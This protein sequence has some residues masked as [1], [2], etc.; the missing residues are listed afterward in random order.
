MLFN[1]TVFLFAFLPVV[2]VVFWALRSKNARYSWL[3]ITGY[4]FYGYW[5]PKF[6]LLMAFSTLVSYTAGLGFLRWGENKRA[7]RWLL[8][9]PIVAD[10]SLLGYFKYAD[11]GLGTINSLLGSFGGHQFSLLHIVLPIGISFY[12]FHTISYIVDCYR[13][14]IKPT[15]NLLEFTSF[16][17]LFSQLIAGPIVRFRELES[18]LENIDR[19]ERRNFLDVGCSFFAIGMIQKVLIA[20]T[21]ASIID[22]ALKDVSSL[23]TVGAWLCMLGYS[24]QLFF[25]FAGYSNMAVG[26][27]FLFGL[28]IPQNF[29]RPYQALNPADF[30]RRWHMS[31]SRVFRDYVFYPLC[32]RGT[33]R[34]RL[35]T[36]TFVTMALVGLWHGANWTFVLWGTYHGLLLVL[37]LSVTKFWDARPARL[38]RVT[39]FFLVLV[40]WTIF[41]APNLETGVALLGRLVIP[42]TGVEIVGSGVLIAMIGIAG[43]WAHFGPD[44]FEISHRWSP[45]RALILVLLFVGCLVR[46]YGAESSPFLYFQF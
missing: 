9:L 14:V 6:T 3:A 21:I 17:S 29:N 42:H 44:T 22:P 25:D 39:M 8:I 5:N 34:R 45:A 12:T 4:V 32:G 30:W 1:S 19:K 43:L 23:S 37:Y 20:D 16:V 26:L 11:F 10:L 18:D 46:I 24:Y 40:G 41:R 38:Q 27:G 33:T 31:L 7:R 35:L 2:Y 15:R 28:R 13:G 36:V